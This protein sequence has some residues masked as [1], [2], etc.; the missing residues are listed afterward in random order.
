[1]SLFVFG[2]ITFQAFGAGAALAAGPIP[3]TSLAGALNASAV[4]IST[5][6]FA[7]R[8]GPPVLLAAP[9]GVPAPPVDA[10][11]APFA[12]LAN[13]IPGKTA[14]TSNAAALPLVS[15]ATSGATP[16]TPG[17][18]LAAVNIL[19]TNTI[20]IVLSSA[21]VAGTNIFAALLSTEAQAL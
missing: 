2:S 8:F 14:Y 21:A 19:D 18:G 17:P 11:S 16:G 7:V 15:V 10:T 6:E 1:M 4:A 12:L 13:F 20:L 9:A 5:T 3:V